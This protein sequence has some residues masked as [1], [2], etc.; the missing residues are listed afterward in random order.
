MGQWPSSDDSALWS[1]SLW[2]AVSKP[3]RW[4]EVYIPAEEIPRIGG[5]IAR[6]GDDKTELHVS[7]GDYSVHHE[8]KGKV[9]PA[10]TTGRLIELAELWADKTNE[11]RAKSDHQKITGM[12]IPI[13]LDDDGVGGTIASF[14]RE[15]GYRVFPI[16]A[17]TK[18]VRQNRYRNKR[19]ELW[20]VTRERA[21]LGKLKLG[22]IPTKI[23]ME[24]RRQA[25]APLWSLNSAGQREV[26]EKDVTKKRLGRSPDSIDALNLSYYVIDSRMPEVMD[27]KAPT[28]QERMEATK[29]ERQPTWRGR[30]GRRGLFRRR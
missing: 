24:L 26:E 10:K 22:L 12:N 18:A 11:A 14:L 16:G 6:H 30:K 15:R 27:I 25:M 13:M 3:L 20:F 4:A 21:K 23:L 28:F 1:D 29:E 8:S 9:D 2:Q 19:S 5:D 7:W 17:A